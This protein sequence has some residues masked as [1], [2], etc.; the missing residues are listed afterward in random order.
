M[1]NGSTQHEQHGAPHIGWWAGLGIGILVLPGVL[2]ADG[3]LADALRRNDFSWFVKFMQWVTWLGYGVLDIS[4]PVVIGVMRRR[5]GDRQGTRR[6]LLGG[7]A[8][9]AA[10]LLGQ[11]IKNLLCRAR[12]NAREAGIFFRSFPCFPA[13][14]ALASFPSGHATTAFAL[15][16]VL[17]LWYPRWTWAWLL[18]AALVGWSRI[19]L[20]SHFPSDV[21]AGALLGAGVVLAF[22]R[23]IPGVVLG[24]EDLRNPPLGS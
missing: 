16:T 1:S 23:W 22:A 9:A 3:S 5:V 20:G 19:V 17:S 8:V 7:L 4:V 2:V 24:R 15:A 10:G 11:L 14:Y 12:P 21:W 13:S 18:V 6:G